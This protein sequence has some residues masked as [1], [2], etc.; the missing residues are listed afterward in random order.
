MKVDAHHH[1]WHPARGD[2]DWM[3][4]DDRTLNRAYGPADLAPELRALGIE[5]TIL[6]QAAATEFET[7]YLLGLADG[8]DMVA[9]VVGWVDFENPGRRVALERFAGHPKFKGV[10]PMIQDI[11]DVDWM[12]RGDVDW[13][14]RAVS[15][16]GLT[17]DALGFPRHMDNFLR[18]LDRHPDMRVVLDHCLK[19]RIHANAPEDFAHW[20]DR[21]TRLARE[22]SAFC[23]FSGL[24]TEASADWTAE[25]LRPHAEHVFAEFGA[26]RVMWGSDWPVCRLRAEYGT[27]HAAARELTA[28]LGPDAQNAIFGGAAASFYGI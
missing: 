1:F 14:F 21:M 25:N 18:I 15:E 3:P 4:K 5:K 28:P 10:R 20:A 22:T 2:Y 8:S 24:V 11:E 19:P 6:V 12:L 16:M 9:G 17:F 23:K 26:D 13:G 7:E 27:W